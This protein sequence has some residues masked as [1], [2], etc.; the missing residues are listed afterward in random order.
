MSVL[1]NDNERPVPQEFAQ[2]LLYTRA[3]GFDEDP[4]YEKCRAFFRQ[5]ALGELDFDYERLQKEFL[6]ELHPHNA[7]LSN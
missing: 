1:L 7:E 3:L 2:Y 4:D 6:T 5:Y